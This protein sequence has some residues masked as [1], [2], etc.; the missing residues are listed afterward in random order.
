ML[1]AL[2]L[3]LATLSPGSPALAQTPSFGSAGLIVE[4]GDGRADVFCLTLPRES[5]TGTE[6]LQLSGLPVGM[7]TAGMGTQICQIG[8]VGCEPGRQHCF[9]QCLGTPCTYW[10]YF[11]WKDAAWI[12]SPLGP[13]LRQVS[14]GDVD[15]WVWGDGTT[16]PATPA[17]A[18]CAPSASAVPTAA[19]TATATAAQP[20]EAATATVA[21]AP[22][23]EASPE[24][25]VS[26]TAEPAVGTGLACP[27]AVLLLLPL[28]LLGA[29]AWARR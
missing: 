15:A 16:L 7:A 17:D 23:S 5:V 22:P 9:C 26:P 27:S 18:A 6:L 10:T 3:V 20:S 11:Y 24:R 12:Y 4:Y 29:L 14:D 8:E 28:G 19:V 13:G 25:T 1:V 21:P 2:L